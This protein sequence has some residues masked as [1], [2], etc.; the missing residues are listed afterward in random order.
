MKSKR[1]F[2]TALVAILTVTTTFAQSPITTLQH[3]GETTVYYG[4][5]SFS[6]ALDAAVDYDT[7]YLSAGYFTAPTIAKGVTVIGSG[8]FPDETDSTGA[9]IQKRTYITSEITINAGADSLHLEGLYI[10]GDIE[11]S[12]SSSIDYVTIIRCRTSSI[13]FNSSSETAAK[14]YNTITECFVTGNIDFNYYGNN[15]TVRNSVIVGSYSIREINGNALIYNNIFLYTY[16]VIYAVSSSVI[17]NNIF[18]ATSNPLYS[19]TS[20]TVSNVISNNLFGSS[21]VNFGYNTPSNNYIGIA[22]ENIFVDQTG[23]SIDYAHNYHLQNITSYLGTDG[24]QV[25]IYGG[26]GFKEEGMPSNP[27][28]TS[29]S[30]AEKTD[31]E[32]NLNI[33]IT[34]EAQDN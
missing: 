1:L 27:Q 32:G 4:V 13:N 29:K 20:E 6:D 9:L 10:N 7:L 23:N 30:I 18:V 15:L 22:Q 25:G 3:N 26:D 31:S 33:S 2:L 17:R 16:R 8:H 12:S 28:I 24:T 34:V 14:N 11:Y 19:Y 21:S 5:S